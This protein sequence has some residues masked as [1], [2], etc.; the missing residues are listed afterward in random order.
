MHFFIS[1]G[2]PLGIEA[3]SHTFKV[4]EKDPTKQI[5]LVYKQVAILHENYNPNQ[6]AAAFGDFL[7]LLPLFGFEGSEVF[8]LQ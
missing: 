4:R 2:I 3:F 6:Y 8:F 7:N 5:I 1:L